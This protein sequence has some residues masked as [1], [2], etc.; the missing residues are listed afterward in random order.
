MS[1]LVFGHVGSGKDLR[2][3]PLYV[4]RERRE[5]IVRLFLYKN[6]DG[7]SHYCTVTNMPGLVSR[8]VRN[9]HGGGT[10]ICDYSLNHVGR[11]DLLSK[12]EESCSK[13]KAVKTEYPKPGENI[14]KFKNIQ[15]CLACPIKFFF[16]TESILKHIDETRG[17]TKLSQ[18][19][20]MSAFCLY[21]VS[22]VEGFSMEPITYVAKDEH[23]EVDR[24]LVEK[25][26]ETAKNVYENFT[27]PAKMIFDEDAR[28]LHESATVCFACGKEFDDDKVRDHCHFTGRYRGAL[29]SKC[30]LKIGGKTLIIPVLAHNNSG[31]DSHMFV[32]RLSDTKGRVSC[33]A[34]NE[35]KYITFSKNI[36][37]DVVGE[38]TW[39]TLSEADRYW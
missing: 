31:Y 17:K 37:V 15:N 6:K 24:V 23:D 8:Q 28:K 16:D 32:K 35:E 7:K 36:L 34:E 1:L 11:Q 38:E 29:H 22:C 33:I 13:Y 39:W 12:H 3:N 19:H 5:K 30:N 27:I 25:M 20:V 2:I 10:H 4:P 18:R 26:V 9:H 21:P 14:Q